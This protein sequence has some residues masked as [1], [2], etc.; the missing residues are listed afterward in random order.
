MNE[1][2]MKFVKGENV[3]S[4]PS[5]N[6]EELSAGAALFIA[7]QLTKNKK[8]EKKLKVFDFDETDDMDDQEMEDQER[9]WETLSI[10]E[11]REGLSLWRSICI[12]SIG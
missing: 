2:A 9:I 11:N 12:A 4:T 7:D 8:K 1:G 10:A 6:D 3:F 5:H